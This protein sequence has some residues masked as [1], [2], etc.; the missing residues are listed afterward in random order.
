MWKPIFTL[1]HLVLLIAACTASAVGQQSTVTIS[2]RITGATGNHP[3]YVALWDGAGLLN[4]PWQSIKIAAHGAAEFQFQVPPGNWAVSAYEDENENGKLDM[5]I[6]GP[7]EPS[8]FW[9][10][11]H[12]WHKPRFSEVSSVVAKDVVAADIQLH[13]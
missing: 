12:G 11:F 9:R 1:R 10:A 3:V 5:G 7:K 8:G 6:F 13:K 4:H 2:G